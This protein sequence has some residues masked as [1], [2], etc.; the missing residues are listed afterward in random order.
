MGPV[1]E[2]AARYASPDGHAVDSRIEVESIHVRERDTF[3]PL[4]KAVEPGAT[5]TL[6]ARIHV[7]SPLPRCRVDF[8]VVRTD[9]TIMFHGSPM[10]E[11]GALEVSEE[12]LERA[13]G[14]AEAFA[15]RL[16]ASPPGHPLW[17]FAEASTS[18]NPRAMFESSPLSGQSNPIAPPLVMRVAGGEGEASA[19]FGVAYEGPPGHVHGG[20]VAAAFDEVLGMVQSL[21]GSPGMTGTLTVRYRRPTP[22]HRQ[23]R[24]A[25]RVD[26]VEGRKIFAVGELY[27]GEPLCAEADAI[28]VRVGTE[29]FQE[30]ARERDRGMQE[31]RP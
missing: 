29:R 31:G 6:D 19:V 3:T 9:G 30:L 8:S 25:A 13:A 5:L 16:A 28:F 11:G 26:H 17:G 21:T 10:V 23:V 7:N 2:M 12:E 18:G 15:E 22:L 4:K 1:A 20:F 27:D 14:A 24:F